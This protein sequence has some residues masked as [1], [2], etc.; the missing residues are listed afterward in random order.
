M[1]N[2]ETCPDLTVVLNGIFLNAWFSSKFLLY[3]FSHYELL[4]P[5]EQ[6][7]DSLYV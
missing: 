2:S 4:S 6:L 1:S 7:W 3:L 5:E